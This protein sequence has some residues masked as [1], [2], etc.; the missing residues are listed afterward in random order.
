MP[1]EDDEHLDEPALEARRIHL[2]DFIELGPPDLVYVRKRYQPMVGKATTRGYY[3]FVRGVDVSSPAKISA[4]VK[5]II[6]NGLDPGGWFATGG[7]TIVGVSYRCWN[8]IS[9]LDMAVDIEIPGGVKIG[10]YDVEGEVIPD[11]EEHLWKEAFVCA[12][13]RDIFEYGE[14]PFYPCLKVV[15][16]FRLEQERYF[17]EC[18]A[19]CASKWDGA[20]AVLRDSKPITCATSIIAGAIRKLFFSNCRYKS[21]IEF[22]DSLEDKECLI[23][24]AGAYLVMGEVEAAVEKVDEAIEL[25]P[26]SSPA[27]DMKAKIL[28]HRYNWDAA[29]RAGKRAVELCAKNSEARITLGEIYLSLGE[30]EAAMLSFNSA[31]MPAPILHNYLRKLIPWRNNL[32]SPVDAGASGTDTVSFVATWKKN[33][34]MRSQQKSDEALQ[35]LPAR[36]MSE[37]ERPVYRGLVK[38]LDIMGWEKLLDVRGKVFVMES[39]MQSGKYETSNGHASNDA[40]A[41]SSDPTGIEPDS[42]DD[43]V[44][45]AAEVADEESENSDVGVM[46]GK[47]VCNP[48]FDYLVTSLYEDLSAMALWTAEEEAEAE[49]MTSELGRTDEEE[50][51]SD[52]E[53]GATPIPL[54]AEEIA[55]MTHRPPVD[56][57]RRGQLAERLEKFERAKTAFRV[58]VAVSEK[59]QTI[60]LTALLALMALYAKEGNIR[61]TLICADKI[62]TFLEQLCPGYRGAQQSR[63]FRP[64]QNSINTLVAT[65]GLQAV[66]EALQVSAGFKVNLARIRSCLLDSV[67]LKVHGVDR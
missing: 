17:L 43:E 53:G 9:K 18:A 62:W 54:N 19:S 41:A 25:C 3:H 37:A 6:T 13:A 40:T 44:H 14:L 47:R 49:G 5:D 46:N 29:L 63:A 57:L 50:G 22:F 16:G 67:T 23:H 2:G 52:V 31:R 45:L 10:A 11:V 12:M 51:S 60:N 39:D 20:G 21:A 32:T 65:S 8:A 1:T 64:V 34:R 61:A 27:Y 4:Y 35:E 30:H 28:L 66:H 56:W 7:W 38:M 42:E 58:C 24:S 55:A 48:S 33:E 36:S 59:A 15:N 26:R